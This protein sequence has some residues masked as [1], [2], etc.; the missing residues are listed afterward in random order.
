MERWRTCSL[1]SSR[2]AVSQSFALSDNKLKQV[3]VPYLYTE[4]GLLTLSD[5][6]SLGA[7]GFVF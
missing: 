5:V 6:E 3:L 1:P 4:L 7:R 2:H